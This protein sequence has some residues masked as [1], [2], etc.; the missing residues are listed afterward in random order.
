[1]SATTKALGAQSAI[2]GLYVRGL[3][4]ITPEADSSDALKSKL[5][6]AFGAGVRLLQYRRKQLSLD[7]QLVE[8]RDFCAMAHAAGATFIVNDNLELAYAVGADGVHWGRE[9]ADLADLAERIAAIK[10]KNPNFIV[11]ISCYNDFARA[12]AA[13]MKHADYI[14]FGSIFASNTKPDAVIAHLD[15]I[16]RAKAAFSIPVVAIGGITRDNVAEVV[17]AGAD[18]V[19]VISDLFSASAIDISDR[20]KSYQTLWTAHSSAES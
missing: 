12:E 8:A 3:Y 7:E 10:A 6:A 1:L 13:N 17:Q 16:R 18:A 19:A 9:D 5:D 4:A 11:G 20:V 15:L 2:R 14:A